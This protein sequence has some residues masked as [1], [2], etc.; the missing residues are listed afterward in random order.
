MFSFTLPAT[1]HH[2]DKRERERE[3]GGGGKREREREREMDIKRD[4]ENL[5]LIFFKFCNGYELG[6]M[7]LFIWPLNI[8]NRVQIEREREREGGGQGMEV[9]E[10]LGQV[11]ACSRQRRIELREGLCRDNAGLLCFDLSSLCISH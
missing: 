6:E 5:N 1:K 2:R 3:R 11:S 10:S 9:L 4:R 7:P 8:N